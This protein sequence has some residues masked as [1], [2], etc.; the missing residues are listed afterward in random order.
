MQYSGTADWLAYGVMAGLGQYGPFAVLA[1]LYWLTALGTLVI[2]IIALV[3][4]MIPIALTL[5]TALGINPQA[6]LMVVAVA[7]TSLASPVSH[8]ANTL[9]MGPGGYRFVHYLKVGGPLTLLLFLLTMLIV[10][11][12]WPLT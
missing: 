9:V 11:L 10:P 1:G 5:S 7:A 4:I 12:V 8:A 6:V 3:L 2:P